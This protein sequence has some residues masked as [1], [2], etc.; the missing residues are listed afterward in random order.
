[1]YNTIGFI[2]S[3]RK[4]KVKQNSGNCVFFFETNY[5]LKTKLYSSIRTKST[6]IK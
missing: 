2:Y 3:K 1:M 5:F 6:I 4:K